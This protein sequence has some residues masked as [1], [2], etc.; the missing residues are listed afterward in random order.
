MQ[1]DIQ[2]K[3]ISMSAN[4]FAMQILLAYLAHFYNCSEG[5]GCSKNKASGG[6]FLNRSWICGS[7][8]IGCQ[9]HN[10]QRNI[11]AL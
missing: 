4:K 8:L 10:N 7:N 5:Y 6:R 11:Y 2:K 3:Y 1:F 9:F